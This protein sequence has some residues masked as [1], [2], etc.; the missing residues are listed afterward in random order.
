MALINYAKY[1]ICIAPKSAKKQGL[2]VGDIARRQYFDAGKT[3]YSLIAVLETGTDLIT[4]AEGEEQESPFFIGALLDGDVPAGGQL[5]DFVRVTNLFDTQR[6]G[7]MYLTASDSNAPYMDIIDGMAQ[8]KSLCYPDNNSECRYALVGEPCFAK[9]Y[10]RQKD[11]C[12]RVLRITRNGIPPSGKAGLEQKVGAGLKNAEKV[13]VSYKIRASKALAALAFT[14]SYADGTETDASGSIDVSTVWEYKFS[15]I[16]ID[17]LSRYERCFFLD[18]SVLG[19]SDWCEI[20]EL[21]IIRLSDISALTHSVKARIGKIQGII[22]PTFGKLEGYGAYF[23]NLYATRNVNVAGTLTAGDESGFASTFYVGRIHKNC[24]INS[25]C[26]NFLQSVEKAPD[27]TAPAGIGEVFRM[28]AGETALIAQSSRWL[29]A[30][31]GGRYCFSFWAKALAPL[32]LTLRQNGHPLQ[33]VEITSKEWERH[34]A[35]FVL[36]CKEEEDLHIEFV[37]PLAGLLLC[38][39]QLEKG[40]RPT[41]YQA[42]DSR[43]DE[44][45]DYGAWFV[46]GG[47]GGTIQNPL[48]KLNE[49]GSLSAG[50]GSFVISK[51]GTGYFAGGRFRW[52]QDAIT[53][54]GVTIRWEDFD[55]EA[56]ANLQAKY[57]TVGGTDTFHYADALDSTGCEPAEA[58]LFATEYNF[59]A[60]RRKWQYLSGGGD[61]KDIA[62]SNADFYLLKPDSHLWE[63]RDVLTLKYVAFLGEAEYFQTYSVSKQYDGAD[64]YS[65]YIDSENGNVFRNGIISTVLSARVMK[66]GEDI[67]GKIPDKNFKWTR[68]SGDAAGDLLWN[69][70]A[71]AGRTLEITGED[72]FR[73]AVFDCEVTISTQ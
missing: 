30:H 42:T 10:F 34:S 31:Q 5:L 66:G 43:L 48:L 21:N 70:A 36:Q 19:E 41:L 6:S 14:F 68:T 7:A 52:T 65:V 24:L 67:T 47:I 55:E 17:Y 12:S 50:D 61:W 37:Y 23:Q 44:T 35:V 53:L 33:E 45:D 22:D 40:E 1:K 27:E 56:K 49:D 72:V 29:Q 51:D 16:T 38:S 3:V 18:L 71:P 9:D 63:E 39:P 4:T 57:V 46:R 69:A 26:G 20:A 73:K 32:T 13:L 2:R 62:G 25:L 28:P 60:T 54:Q 8:E 15:L 58:M 11:G 64:S 59:A